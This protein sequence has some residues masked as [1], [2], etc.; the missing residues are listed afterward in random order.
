MPRGVGWITP[1]GG[2]VPLTG[3]AHGA[4]GIAWA[5]LRLAAV[6][7]E[8]RFADLAQAGLEYER[9][10]YLPSLGN[11][12]DLRPA[13]GGGN[14]REGGGGSGGA[15]AA[16]GM[17]AWC[18]GA[19]GIGLARLASLD[20]L[21]NPLVRGEIAT[22]LETTQRQ[23]MGLSHALCHGDLG[24]IELLVAATQ[25]LGDPCWLLAARR[26]A[27]GILTTATDRGWLCATPFGLESPGLM[28]GLAGIGYA[29]LR[30][31]APEQVPS[32]LSLA[33]VHQLP[34]TSCAHT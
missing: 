13:G 30:L 26:W 23:G 8:Q 21:D 27:A 10:V 15:A 7:G 6:S 19:P 1:A 25:T 16:G 18:H 34:G 11:W 24:N 31:S 9:S 29:L 4:A 17:V 32:L 14:G 2:D 28:T 33:S 22:A 20:V 3:F 12:P 5:L